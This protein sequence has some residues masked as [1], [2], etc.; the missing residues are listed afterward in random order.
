M[1][2]AIRVIIEAT[3]PMIPVCL[4]QPVCIYAEPAPEFKGVHCIK[5]NMYFGR[6]YRCSQ[7][8]VKGDS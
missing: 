1:N 6:R 5:H 4:Q 8:E 7:K 3:Q 2:E